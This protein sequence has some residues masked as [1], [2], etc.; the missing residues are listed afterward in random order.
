MKVIE[1]GGIAG[2]SVCS[3]TDY[4]VVGEAYGSKAAKALTLGITTLTEQEFRDLF[5][6]DIPDEEPLSDEELLALY[7]KQEG[8]E[9]IGCRKS[10]L[11][12]KGTLYNT[13]ALCE[14]GNPSHCPHC[15]SEVVYYHEYKEY[16]CPLCWIWFKAPF[17]TYAFQTKKHLCKRIEVGRSEGGVY[18]TCQGCQDVKYQTYEAYTESQEKYN[19]APNMVK[20]WSARDILIKESLKEKED[21][22]KEEDRKYREALTPEILESTRLLYEKQQERIKRRQDRKAGVSSI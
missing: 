8:I 16:H 15:N 20:E 12:W 17:S 4:L 22:I 14:L 18:Y 5:K 7:A 3:T 19:R 10:F 6:E 13:C 11:R 9:C 21:K 2:S 1:A